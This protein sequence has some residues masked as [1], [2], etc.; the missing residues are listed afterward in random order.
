[1]PGLDKSIIAIAND[2]QLRL[3]RPD[4]SGA[5]TTWFHAG[6]PPDGHGVW[7]DLEAAISDGKLIIAGPMKHLAYLDDRLGTA[8]EEKLIGLLIGDIMTVPDAHLSSHFVN[9]LSSA[10]PAATQ[11]R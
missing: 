2:E 8:A 9:F 10:E 11:A 3:V 5:L 7:A 6:V 1:M 4:E